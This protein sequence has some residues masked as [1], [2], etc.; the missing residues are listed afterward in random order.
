MP[1]YQ[2][3]FNAVLEYRDVLGA[4][5]VT[6]LRVLALS[7]TTGIVLGLLLAPLRAAHSRWLRWPAQAIIEVVRSIPPLV[8]V[9]W[10]YYCL[11]ILAGLKLSAYWTTVLALGLYGSVFFAEIF[12]AGLQ[13]V[14]PGQIEAALSV[15]MTPMKALIRV[16][17]PIAFLRILPAFV[18]QCVMSVKNSVLGSYIAVGELLYEGQR[19]STATFR[20]LE[21]LTFVAVFFVVTILPLS[22]LA[23]VIE[24]RI[25]ARFFRR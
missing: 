16:T 5:I 13:S 24:N 3:D 15:G 9:V 6:T 19:L 7:V 21:V 1:E 14:D 11:P 8:L 17:A 2:W 18:G 25:Q 10:A 22:L 12:R 20:P 4:G 23:S